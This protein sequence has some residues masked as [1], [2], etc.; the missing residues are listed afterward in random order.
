MR[1][2]KSIWGLP[3]LSGLALGFVLCAGAGGTDSASAAP[4]QVR[5]AA[6]GRAPR[7]D[8]IVVTGKVYRP[9]VFD[10][11]QR[12]QLGLEWDLDDLRFKQSFLDKVLRSVS[13]QPF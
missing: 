12:H 2:G 10:L 1:H 8:V 9:A 5:A 6:G 4:G 3:V 7:E 11:L 13:S